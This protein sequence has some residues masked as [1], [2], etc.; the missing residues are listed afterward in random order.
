MLKRSALKN[1]TMRYTFTLPADQPPGDVSVV[2]TFNDWEPGTHTLVA[3]GEGQR[4]ASVTLPP[5]EHRFRYLATGGL[6]FD[7]DGA[8]H[9]DEHGGVLRVPS[10]VN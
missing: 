8:D 5:G 1:G 6:W 9:V 4:R 3:D 2:G 10:Q 7:D